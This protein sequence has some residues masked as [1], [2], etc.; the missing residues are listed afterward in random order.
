MS[1][2]P[3]IRKRL[4]LHIAFPK[5][6]DLL[7]EKHVTCSDRG[8]W[9]GIKGHVL[10]RTHV[11]GEEDMCWG[12]VNLTRCQTEQSLLRSVQSNVGKTGSMHIYKVTVF[13]GRYHVIVFNPPQC[14][15]LVNLS[16]GFKLSSTQ[17]ASNTRSSDGCTAYNTDVEVPLHPS[18]FILLCCYQRCSLC[19][20]APA[21]T[22]TESQN[23]LSPD[24]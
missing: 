8:R 1:D 20:P 4:S 23:T 19:I 21:C 9:R 13:Q 16:P 6:G 17:A 3:H 18:L 22:G 12:L 11:K 15:I 5:W 7:Y 2:C 14:H 10:S 24:W